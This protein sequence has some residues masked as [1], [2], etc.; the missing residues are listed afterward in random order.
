MS[1]T[2]YQPLH[3]EFSGEPRILYESGDITSQEYRYIKINFGD[4][5]VLSRVEIAH[6]GNPISTGDNIAPSATLSVSSTN[7]LYTKDKAVDGIKNDNDSRWISVNAA[8]AHWF[9]LDWPAG[10]V[11][12]NVKVWSGLLSHSGYQILDYDIQYWDGT[13]WQTAGS[14]SNNTQDGYSGQYNNVTF[15][16]VTTNKIKLNITD[17]CANQSQEDARLIEIEVYG[18]VAYILPNIGPNADNSNILHVYTS[19]MGQNGRIQ[20]KFTTPQKGI[21]NLNIFDIFGKNILAN[22]GVVSERGIQ[23]LIINNHDFSNGIYFIQL[24]QGMEKATSRF[25]IKK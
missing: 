4:S 3:S 13:T 20:V 22:K 16:A 7:G 2:V 21:Y 5:D 10:K 1:R 24:M 6:S 11:I 14:V 19:V 15:S 18:P 23:S 12:D 25:V 9:Q 17:P 8:E